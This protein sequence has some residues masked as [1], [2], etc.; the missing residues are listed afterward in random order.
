[1]T[2][3]YTME[4]RYA[5]AAVNSRDM[6]TLAAAGMAGQK[7]GNAT[8]L[9]R[10]IDSMDAAEYP[11]VIIALSDALM[12]E[13]KRQNTQNKTRPVLTPAGAKQ[14]ASLFLGYLI[15]PICPTCLGRGAG[16]IT[17]SARPV[18]GESCKQCSGTGKRKLRREAGAHGPIVQDLV[19]WLNGE[20]LS[21]SIMAS[22]SVA[23]KRFKKEI[24][25]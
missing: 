15:A 9:W 7:H 21:Q 16:L 20:V 17:G 23:R 8:R 25:T 18:L 12:A 24:D 19:M 11:Q 13:S 3:I 14:C 4:E 1:M 10:L 2:D 22:R 5:E 6:D